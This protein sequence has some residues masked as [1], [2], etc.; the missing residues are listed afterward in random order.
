MLG[1]KA[2]FI[3][4]NVSSPNTPGLRE[5]QAPDHWRTPKHARDS[6]RASV[7]RQIEPPLLVKI[8]PDLEAIQ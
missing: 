5:W 4:M 3:V 6:D 1:P 7:D 8:A 2:D